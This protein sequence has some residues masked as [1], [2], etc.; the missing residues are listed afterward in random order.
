MMG[1]GSGFTAV[2]LAVIVHA[3][4][5]PIPL[6]CSLNKGPWQPCQM[7]VVAVGQSW[8]VVVAGRRI[9][10]RHDGRGK[11]EMNSDGTWVVVTPHWAADRSLCWES[12]CLRGDIPLD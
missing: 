8:W 12:L 4:P 3:Q 7:E 1:V 5:S 2:G 6:E 9:A 10:F 11:V